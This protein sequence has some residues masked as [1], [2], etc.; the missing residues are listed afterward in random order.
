ME[1]K[2]WLKSRLGQKV[3]VKDLGTCA[4]IAGGWIM[5]SR[6]EVEPGFYTVLESENGRCV[7]IGPEPT[8]TLAEDS[9]ECAIQE[10]PYEWS[11]YVE[12]R[13][14]CEC[15]HCQEPYINDVKRA[16]GG[17]CTV[18]RDEYGL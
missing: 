16:G 9:G 4:L 5:G 8:R 7:E 6:K 3:G 15:R 1:S 13:G 14:D 18:C 2:P 11:F 10:W 17:V 12:G